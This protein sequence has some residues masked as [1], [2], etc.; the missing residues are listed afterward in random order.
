MVIPLFPPRRPPPL[1]F[2][3]FQFITDFGWFTNVS[4]YAFSSQGETWYNDFGFSPSTFPEPQA[5][6][7]EYKGAPLNFHMGGIRKPRLGN[8]DLL[9][10]ARRKGWLLPGGEASGVAE[11]ADQRNL[12]FSIPAARAWYVEQQAH[13]IDEGVDFFWNDEGETDWYVRR[14]LILPPLVHQDTQLKYQGGMTTSL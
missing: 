11:Y 4:D 13:Y 1:V 3:F 5:Q 10:F 7:T 12:D 14:C 2:P 9:N 6:L 8:T